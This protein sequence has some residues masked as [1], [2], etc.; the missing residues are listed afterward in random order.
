VLGIEARALQRLGKCSA[1]YL[2]VHSLSVA[3]IFIN[4]KI[5]SISIYPSNEYN[6]MN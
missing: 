6:Y 1:L 2:Y 3:L 5:A 4:F